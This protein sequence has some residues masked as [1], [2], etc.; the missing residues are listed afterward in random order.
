[1][2]RRLRRQ[3]KHQKYLGADEDDEGLEAIEVEWEDGA[4]FKRF[5]LV[6]KLV[7]AVKDVQL[8][9]DY[10]TEDDDEDEDDGV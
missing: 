7:G 3:R 1:M 4:R 9:A 10:D 6:P 2:F 5:K 8:N